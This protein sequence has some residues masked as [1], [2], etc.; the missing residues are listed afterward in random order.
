M[1]SRA[2]SQ[3]ISPAGLLVALGIIYGDIGTSPLY[4]LSEIVGKGPINKEVV[5]GAI[6]CIF[7]T[8]TLS[9]LIYIFNIYL[10]LKILSIKYFESTFNIDRIDL[11]LFLVSKEIESIYIFHY[12]VLKTLYFILL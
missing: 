10:F 6:S 8:L 5:L 9:F 12:I 7:W 3:N 1:S 11:L 4:V 2:H